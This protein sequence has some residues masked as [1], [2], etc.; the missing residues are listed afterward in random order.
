M[1][2]GEG[3]DLFSIKKYPGFH[4]IEVIIHFL[5]EGQ[6]NLNFARSLNT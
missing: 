6:T 3:G 5:G 1:N 2:A 4:Y